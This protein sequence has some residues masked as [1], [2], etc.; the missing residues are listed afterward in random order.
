TVGKPVP[1]PAVPKLTTALEATYSL[2][3]HLNL[4]ANIGFLISYIGD[5]YTLDY[6]GCFSAL[7]NGTFTGR[8]SDYNRWFH[9]GLTT[10]NIWAGYDI[11][12]HISAEF[13]IENAFNNLESPT[14]GW[15]VP[16]RQFQFTL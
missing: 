10:I 6:R 12:N 5:R 11:T 8:T 15:V 7:T 14:P 9:D 13:R 1:F 16:G 3:K 4:P 2:E